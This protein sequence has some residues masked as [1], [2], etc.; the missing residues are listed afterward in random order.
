MAAYGLFPFRLCPCLHFRLWKCFLQLCKGIYTLI[1]KLHSFFK[2]AFVIR[3]GNIYIII[4]ATSSTM[5][6]RQHEK[7]V[8][9][10]CTETPIG[11]DHIRTQKVHARIK[12][13][14]YHHHPAFFPKVCFPHHLMNNTTPIVQPPYM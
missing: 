4:T 8:G 12:K 11:L 5:H 13:R 3:N 7:T 10:T 1:I 2:C 9:I 6:V 14:Q